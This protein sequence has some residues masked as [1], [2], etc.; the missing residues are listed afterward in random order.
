MD[1]S[2]LISA[3]RQCLD[4][5]TEYSFEIMN[6]EHWCG[7]LRS[8]VT[9]TA[10]YVFLHQVL[11]SSLV[12]DR[13]NLRRWLLSQ[14]KEDGSWGIAPNHSGD[15]STTNEAYLA[16]KLLGTFVSEPQMQQAR[17]FIGSA[18][19]RSK[20]RVLT[21]F[22]LATFGLWPWE[23][24]PELPAELILVSAFQIT[25]CIIGSYHI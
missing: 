17:D 19:G 9:I 22:Y 14:Q 24:I 4:S 23:S 12:K 11:G 2:S 21:R 6:N 20:V 25:T 13:E 5:A 8:N 3:T 1:D 15:V 10:E 18:G 7:E 16:L